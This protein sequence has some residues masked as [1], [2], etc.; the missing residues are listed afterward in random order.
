MEL[1]Y[2]LWP[3]GLVDTDNSIAKLYQQHY[4]SKADG[5]QSIEQLHQLEQQQP[6]LFA[7][8][9]QFIVQKPFSSDQH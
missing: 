7:G 9:Y 6:D 3:V 8:M 5:P 2:G 1:F 4:G